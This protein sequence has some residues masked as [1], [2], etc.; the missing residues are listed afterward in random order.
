MHEVGK[1]ER[2]KSY[3][4]G[5]KKPSRLPTVLTLC[6]SN[7][8]P[9]PGVGFDVREKSRRRRGLKPDKSDCAT[10][11]ERLG[12]QRCGADHVPEPRALLRDYPSRAQIQ[13]LCRCKGGD[14]FCRRAAPVAARLACRALGVTANPLHFTW[15]LIG[16]R[17]RHGSPSLCH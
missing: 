3:V 17:C 4:Y 16:S 10:S 7:A 5:N 1:I 15:K 11:E 8:A 2:M 6:M 14:V 13:T 9:S 12:T